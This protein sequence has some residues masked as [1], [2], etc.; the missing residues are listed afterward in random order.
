MNTLAIRMNLASMQALYGSWTRMRPS[1]S[2]M[3]SEMSLCA[4]L[5]R[6]CVVGSVSLS[7]SGVPVC[8]ILPSS[9][10]LHHASESS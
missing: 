2:H 5:L 8:C 9:I 7:V 6:F 4:S 10:F 1:H 3:V